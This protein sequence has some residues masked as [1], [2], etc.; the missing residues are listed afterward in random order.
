M[1]IE[2]VV[3]TKQELLDLLEPGLVSNGIN[4]NAL[5]L[6][7][8]DISSIGYP[9]REFSIDFS[10]PEKTVKSDSSVATQDGTI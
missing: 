1:K 7:I 2:R 6:Q 3:V 8:A 4:I 5:G 10:I 9:I